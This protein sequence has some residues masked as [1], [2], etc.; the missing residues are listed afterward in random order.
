[1]QRETDLLSSGR[2]PALRSVI[3]W[4][5]F[6]PLNHVGFAENNFDQVA[7]AAG[8][9]DTARRRC[10]L[11]GQCSSVSQWRDPTSL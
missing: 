9:A 8:E 1:M 11:N 3:G 6:R 2:R 10:Q 7:T 4:V 5:Q